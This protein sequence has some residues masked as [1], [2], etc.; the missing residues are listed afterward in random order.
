MNNLTVKKLSFPALDFHV[1]KMCCWKK[2]ILD[3]YF[4]PSEDFFFLPS[5]KL[6]LY[7]P[8]LYIVFGNVWINVKR[9]KDE[10]SEQSG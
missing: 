6:C 1:H 4:F 8:N 7:L 10:K 2:Y 9:K 3:D 5:T